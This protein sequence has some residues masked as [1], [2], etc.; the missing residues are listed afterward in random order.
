[1]ARPDELA[2]I[3]KQKSFEQLLERFSTRKAGPLLV[4]LNSIKDAR[5]KLGPA[6]RMA[7]FA[8]P[9][10]VG[11]K[12]SIVFQKVDRFWYIVN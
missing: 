9:K 5:P 8:L 2:Q 7:T 6:G 11:S 10:P 12:K 1:M 3:L 4:I